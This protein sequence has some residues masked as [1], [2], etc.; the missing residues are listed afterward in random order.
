ML[1]G[2]KTLAFGVILAATAIFSSVE[3]QAFIA[4]HIPSIGTFIGTVVI[5]LRAVTNSSIFK[6]N[7][8]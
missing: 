4:E 7:E 1:G 3:V 5:V 6:P 8:K 2:F